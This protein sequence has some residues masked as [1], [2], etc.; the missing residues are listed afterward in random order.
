MNIEQLHSIARLHSID[1]GEL[2]KG[3]LIKSIQIAEGN[4]DCYATAN[5]ECDQ[6]GCLWRDDCF[7]AA[8]QPS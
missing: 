1:P 7:E 5:G 3:E 4:F 6:A 8:Q 2:S